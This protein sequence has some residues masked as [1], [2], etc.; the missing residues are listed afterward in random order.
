MHLYY[1]LGGRTLGRALTRAEKINPA[2]KGAG[3]FCAWGAISQAQKPH[4]IVNF[5]PADH[6]GKSCVKRPENHGKRA[7][8]RRKTSQK[9]PKNEPSKIA[10]LPS[11]ATLSKVRVKDP[12]SGRRG[13]ILTPYPSL[14]YDE[15]KHNMGHGTPLRVH[16][17]RWREGWRLCFTQTIP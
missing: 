17:W 16:P 4:E 14:L 13:I 6:P 3:F 9:T 11:V 12:A 5:S 10:P 8:K 1:V 2:L 15:R 7:R